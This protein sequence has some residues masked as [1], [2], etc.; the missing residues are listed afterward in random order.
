[1]INSH[2]HNN[3]VNHLEVE[4]LFKKVQFYW[5]LNKLEEAHLVEPEMKHTEC[6]EGRF[7]IEN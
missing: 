2:Y 7:E 4:S 3:E 1:M 6:F 5:N